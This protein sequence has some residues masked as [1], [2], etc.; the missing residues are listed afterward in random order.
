MIIAKKGTITKSFSPLSWEL[1][2]DNKNGWVETSPVGAKPNTI[3][4]TGQKE[5]PKPQVAENILTKEIVNVSVVE[6]KPNTIPEIVVENKTAFFELAKNSLTK[7]L[8]K[9]YFDKEEVSVTYKATDNLDT[10][11]GLLHDNLQGDIELLKSKF[12]L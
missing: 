10:L 1:L 3:P 12:S 9:D 7:N 6:T 8:I 11:I 5:E 2:G 4:E